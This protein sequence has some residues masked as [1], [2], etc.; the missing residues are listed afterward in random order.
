M[1][2]KS[3]NMKVL[4]LYSDKFKCTSL[5]EKLK[6]NNNEIYQIESLISRRCY[7]YRICFYKVFNVHMYFLIL[8][9]FNKYLFSKIVLSLYLL[10]SF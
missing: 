5:L 1:Q 3:L 8:L 6:N 2:V 7:L 10:Y 4:Q 9:Y